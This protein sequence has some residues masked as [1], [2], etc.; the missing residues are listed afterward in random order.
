LSALRKGMSKS[1]VSPDCET[2]IM[3]VDSGDLN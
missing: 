2:Q 1:I 3:Q